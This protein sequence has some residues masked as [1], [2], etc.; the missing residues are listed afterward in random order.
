MII[1]VVAA[2]L[3]DDRGRVLLAQRPVGKHLAGTWEFPGGK[4]EPDE[5]P[6]QGLVRELAEELA[7]AVEQSEPLL[8]L[9][10][11]YPGRSVR[12]LLRE[13]SAWQGRPVGREGQALAWVSL[14]EAQ[15]LP[16]PPADRPMLKAL[17]LDPR[18]SISPDPSGFAA[19]DAFLDDWRARLEA[20]FGWL[21]LPAGG[22]ATAGLHSLIERC[23]TL[24]HEFGARCSLLAPPRDLATAL[25]AY[26]IHLDTDQLRACRRRPLAADRLVTA[27][28]ETAEDL[29][30]A[31]R[32]GLDLVM[33]GP[34]C[35]PLS[36]PLPL[37]WSGLEECCADSPLPVLA[38]GGLGPEDLAQARRA[39]A[40]G[41]AGSDRFGGS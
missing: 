21:G 10:H 38:T 31:G 19:P 17:A 35:S 40:F 25:P 13:V 22:P 18:L 15:R 36:D 37:G 3:R 12:L 6:E 39:G 16:M 27:D 7:I 20:G 32:L 24:A 29:A 30:L 1:P 11:H 33:V 4:L 9:T 14:A 28:C 41:V 26:G 8:S 23:C 34:I 2:V 5:S